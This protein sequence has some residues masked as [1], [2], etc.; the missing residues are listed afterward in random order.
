MQNKLK[1]NTNYFPIKDLCIV[2]IEER[3]KSEAACYIYP[4]MQQ[5]YFEAYKTAEKIF[6]YFVNMYKNSNKL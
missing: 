4:C 3:T 1:S 6:E 5:D 2:Y